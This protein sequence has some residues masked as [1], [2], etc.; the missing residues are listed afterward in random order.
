M[1]TIKKTVE[2][3][4]PPPEYISMEYN[5]HIMLAKGTEI[6]IGDNIYMVL[7]CEISRLPDTYGGCCGRSENHTTVVHLGLVKEN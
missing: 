4:I 3:K 1:F 6:S 2:T 7:N 5:Q